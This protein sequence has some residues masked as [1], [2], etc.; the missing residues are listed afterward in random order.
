MAAKMAAIVK[1][2]SFNTIHKI[3]SNITFSTKC[4]TRNPFLKLILWFEVNNKVK[5]HIQG[6]LFYKL[7][8]QI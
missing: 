3:S 4:Y 8:M 1:K 5:Y 6:Y 7:K 2:K